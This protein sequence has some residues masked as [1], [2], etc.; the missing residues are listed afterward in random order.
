MRRTDREWPI[1]RV[2][3]TASAKPTDPPFIAFPCRVISA[4]LYSSACCAR[5]PEAGTSVMAARHV[6]IVALAPLTAESADQSYGGKAFN[7][8]KVRMVCDGAAP[9]KFH[10][11][12]L[13]MASDR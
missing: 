8:N 9:A 3:R 13:R 12:I 5:P 6:P 2:P 1:L 11:K 4:A 10:W 7:R